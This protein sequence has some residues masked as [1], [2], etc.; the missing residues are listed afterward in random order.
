MIYNIHGC[1]NLT[2]AWEEGREG[3]ETIVANEGRPTLDGVIRWKYFKDDFQENKD[4][5]YS[6]NP[7]N[8]FFDYMKIG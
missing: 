8:K 2:V 4:H 5:R 7:L 1:P 6:L 3:K